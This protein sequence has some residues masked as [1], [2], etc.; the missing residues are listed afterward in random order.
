ME[1][2]DVCSL[3]SVQMIINRQAAKEARGYKKAD[4]Y[5]WYSPTDKDSR[6]GEA[7]LIGSLFFVLTS[8]SSTEDGS[9]F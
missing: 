5:A 6:E 8:C 9:V 4:P 3:S 1:L 2:S 7:H